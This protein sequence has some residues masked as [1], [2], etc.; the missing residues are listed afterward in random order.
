MDDKEFLSNF[1]ALANPSADIKIQSAKK[2]ARTL[3]AL[4]ALPQHEKKSRL[5]RPELAN[6]RAR[7]EGGDLGA[8]VSPD[9]NYALKRLVC[10]VMPNPMPGKGSW[11]R[12]VGTQEGLLLY[13]GDAC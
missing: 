7:F 9:L 6:F 4:D 12:S 5:D 10:P 11:L 3:L 1:D 13:T 2:I 8:S